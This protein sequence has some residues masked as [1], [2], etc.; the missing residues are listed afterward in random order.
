MNSKLLSCKLTTLSLIR[1]ADQFGAVFKPSIKLRSQEYKTLLGGLLSIVIYGLSFSYFVYGIYQWQTNQI[2]PGIVSYDAVQESQD[3]QTGNE[4]TISFT[5]RI[6]SSAAVNPFNKSAVI[7]IALKYLFVDGKATKNF[8]RIPIINGSLLQN[9]MEIIINSTYHQEY[10]TIITD[11]M[12]YFLE[13]D[14]QCASNSTI[15]QFWSQ[16][17]IMSYSF[18]FQQYNTVDRVLNNISKQYFMVINQEQT[19]YNQVYIK[20]TLTQADYGLLFPDVYNYQYISDVSQTSQSL[21][22]QTFT[23]LFQV[24]IYVIFAVHMDMLQT[25]QNIQFP[26]ISQVLADI[27]SIVSLIL[28]LSY[29][30]I[31]LNQKGLEEEAK[32]D[33]IKM[34]FPTIDQIEVKKNWYGKVLQVHNPITKQQFEVKQYKDY[35]QKLNDIAEQKLCFA[36]QIFE[37]SRLQFAIQK[38]IG[39]EELSKYRDINLKVTLQAIK[40][41]VVDESQPFQFRNNNQITPAQENSKGES[42]IELRDDKQDNI[43]TEQIPKQDTTVE[44]VKQQPEEKRELI[45]DV[46][47]KYEYD[48]TDFDLICMIRNEF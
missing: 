47:I 3:F 16:N 25:Q 36:N 28:F 4:T 44:Q 48:E 30:A 18:Y 10:Y 14:E 32:Q 39:K 1:E 6:D 26:N 5:P 29:I 37:M 11:C 12:P 42:R 40:N 31:L 15:K 13:S 35:Y 24:P 41:L 43:L 9:N 17:N 46:E 19:F 2:L 22:I 23:S 21:N 45:Q 34:F 7:M 33:I 20:S 8:T 38:L 27:G